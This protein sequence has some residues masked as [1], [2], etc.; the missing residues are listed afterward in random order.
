MT[1]FIF[2]TPHGTYLRSPK[3]GISFRFRFMPVGRS[4]QPR[5]RLEIM[6]FDVEEF[7]L[8]TAR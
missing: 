4:L 3:T 1:P 8:R 6:I 7:C 5:S 2:F